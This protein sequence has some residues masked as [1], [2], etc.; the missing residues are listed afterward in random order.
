[1]RGRRRHEREATM[2]AARRRWPSGQQHRVV[3]A[4]LCSL[5]VIATSASAQ[6]IY[7]TSGA[8]GIGTT[9]P[10]DALQIQGADS[11]LG[12][13]LSNTGAG[14]RQFRLITTNSRSSAQGGQFA[15]LDETQ[16]AVRLGIEPGGLLRIGD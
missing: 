4:G 7:P 8:V 13:R 1:M 10:A 9:S 16:G 14:G 6:N 15:I 5:L 3:A 11:N 2:M 12:L